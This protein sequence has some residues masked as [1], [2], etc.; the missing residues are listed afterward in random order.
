MRAL[1]RCESRF[2][3]IAKRTRECEILD[4]MN[5]VM[6]CTEQVLLIKLH[7]WVAGEVPSRT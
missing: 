5:L 1:R 6:P 7:V 4:E 2:D 3:L